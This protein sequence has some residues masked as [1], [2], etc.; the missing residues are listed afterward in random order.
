M[1]IQRISR[2]DFDGY[3]PVRAEMTESVTEETDWYQDTNGNIIGAVF[4]ERTDDDWGYVI[5]G[6]DERGHFRC[7][8]I[9]ACVATEGGAR[10][11]LIAAMKKV[12]ATGQ[13]EFPQEDDFIP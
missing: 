3:K 2:S 1:A 9:E 4:R 8:D 5:L 12:E 10:T 6:R 7:F 11:S 13:T